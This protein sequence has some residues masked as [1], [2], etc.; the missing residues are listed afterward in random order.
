MD[1]NKLIGE[2]ERLKKEKDA[3]ILAHNYQLPQIQDIADILGDSLELAKLS[4]DIGKRV[5]VFCGV[6]FMA[7]TAKILSPSK[8]VLLPAGDAGCPLADT[9]TEKDL[10]A[11][12]S[13]YPG[14]KVVS[15]VNSSAL[16]K[17]ESDVCCTSSNAVKIVENINSDTV[18]FVPDKNLAAWVKKKVKSKKIILHSGGCYVHEQFSLE[19]IENMKNKYPKAKVLVHPEC[20]SE[21]QD[22]ADFVV[23]T[24]GM[25]KTAGEEKTDEFIIGTEKGMLYRLEKENP[26]KKFYSLGQDRECLDMK[27]TTLSELYSCLEEENNEVRLPAQIMDKARSALEGMVKYL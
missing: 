8:R 10:L 7:E 22:K 20:R 1:K 19:D 11:L 16:V 26:G 14:A 24:S 12:K 17:A 18:I 4:K 13:R 3:V 2:I 9:I 23:S 15:Y 5:I 21:V 6:R 27:K 25:L